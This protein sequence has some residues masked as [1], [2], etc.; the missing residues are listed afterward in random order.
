MVS[1]LL[2]GLTSRK[3]AGK[4]CDAENADILKNASHIALAKKAKKEKREQAI[5]HEPMELD[6]A[7]KN[8]DAVNKFVSI[9]DS[10]KPKNASVHYLL[11][12][13]DLRDIQPDMT[14]YRSRRPAPRHHRV[15][16]NHQRPAPVTSRWTEGCEPVCLQCTHTGHMSR[17]YSRPQ[18]VP[19]ALGG[20]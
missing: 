16:R 15:E 18:Y 19:T 20:Q 4:V 3:L 13:Q 9:M 12:H 5:G 11:Q 8:Y 6:S 2:R 14:R 1:S 17:P 10:N 7:H